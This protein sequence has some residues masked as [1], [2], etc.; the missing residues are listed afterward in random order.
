L[1]TVSVDAFLILDRSSF[2]RHD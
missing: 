1:N 2:H